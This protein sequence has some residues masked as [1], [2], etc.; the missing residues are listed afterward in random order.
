MLFRSGFG[1]LATEDKDQALARSGPKNN[2]GADAAEA[3][4]EIANVLAGIQG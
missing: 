3:A 4:I 1:V 2:A